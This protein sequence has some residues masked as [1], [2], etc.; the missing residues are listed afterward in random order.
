[1][2]RIRYPG[3]VILALLCTLLL[4]LLPAC[5]EQTQRVSGDGASLLLGLPFPFYTILRT[6]AD[7]FAVHFDIGG[8]FADFMVFYGA[9]WLGMR[10]T[11]G[12]RK[13]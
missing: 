11:Q 3:L 8:L 5:F 2:K 13:S 1:M 7:S 6:P 9:L 10:L 12:I 4:A